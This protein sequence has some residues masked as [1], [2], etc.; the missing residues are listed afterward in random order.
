MSKRIFVLAVFALLAIAAV[1]AFAQSTYDWSMVGSA[2]AVDPTSAGYGFTGPGLRFATS[3]TGTIVA[4]YPVTNTYGSSQ[5]TAPGWQYLVL[6]Y[7]L[8]S[9]LGTVSARLVRVDECSNTEEEMCHISGGSGVTAACDHCLF[10]P[11]ELNFASNSYYVEV[12]LTRS[13]TS[14]TPIVNTVALGY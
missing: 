11:G 4:R 10:N 7:G 14:A 6:S 12:T 13:A 9:A 2:G 1:P 3:T 8:N 5:S